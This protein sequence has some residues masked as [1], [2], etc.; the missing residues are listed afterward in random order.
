M[1]SAPTVLNK[2]CNI[3]RRGGYYPPAM[4][5]LSLRV[6]CVKTKGAVLRTA[7]KRIPTSPAA[8]RNDRGWKTAQVIPLHC[9]EKHIFDDK[10]SKKQGLNCALC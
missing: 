9:R 3:D 1:I 6:P 10:K 8:P 4:L 2:T 7:R 5:P